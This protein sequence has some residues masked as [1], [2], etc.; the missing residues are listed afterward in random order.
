M[1]ADVVIIGGGLTALTAG[2][3]LHKA[4][5]RTII[6]SAGQSCVQFSSG[7][8][9]MLGE[10]DGQT[11]TNP[12]EALNR[13][14]ASHP[15]SKIGAEAV[16]KYLDSVPALFKEAGITVQGATEENH[17][18]LTPIG[19]L[20]PAWLSFSDYPL[21]SMT[22]I[23]GWK[24]AA[25][26]NFK[27]YIDFYPSFLARGLESY[28]VRCFCADFSISAMDHLRKSA[29]E[30][31]ATTMARVLD[32]EALV[33]LA[34]ALNTLSADADVILMPA[35]VGLYSEE[36]LRKLRGMVKKP[37]LMVPTMPASVPGV[38]AQ[39]CLRDYYEKCGGVY[40]LGDTV[41]SGSISNGKLEYVK[42]AN[43]GD[44][45]LEAD[46]F[47]LATGSFFS[48]GLEVLP[49]RIRE[50][51]FNLDTDVPDQ[52]DKWFDRDFLHSQPY[53]TYGVKTD[54]HFR[55]FL[56]G[57]PVTNLRAAG[58]ILG[59]YNPMREGSGGGVALATAM[60]VTDE[61]LKRK[62]NGL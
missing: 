52:R 23:P 36:P 27:G 58:A 10:V 13:L 14:P 18:R 17:L 59:G 6:V 22:D 49:D 35:V 48:Y 16:K 21:I 1:K 9:E 60:A 4:G 44:T 56:A 19:E 15:Y 7:S 43:L 5:K 28:G 39:M 62:E 12:A 40:L 3:L 57:T 34:D 54:N 32:G 50:T 25:L 11:V 47:I 2:I 30:M 55:T 37:L 53:M 41:V 42:T 33:E 61:I 51:I 26:L 31:R 45:R 29:S 46:E 8:L 38:R 24:S 20:K